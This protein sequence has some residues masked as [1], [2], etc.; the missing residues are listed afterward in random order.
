MGLFS[1]I[2]RL[3]Q[4]AQPEPFTVDGIPIVRISAYA[5]GREATVEEM[6][7]PMQSPYYQIVGGGVGS[8]MP[9]STEQYDPEPGESERDVVERIAQAVAAANPG[10][11]VL[12]FDW[13]GRTPMLIAVF[14]TAREFHAP[15]KMSP[16]HL[17]SLPAGNG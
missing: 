14:V 8:V 7:A 1:W 16:R 5:R 17:V 4:P 2:A 3:F 12:A 10:K 9:C 13:P 6:M 15:K 11:A